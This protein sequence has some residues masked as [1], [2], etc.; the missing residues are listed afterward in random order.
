MN[1]K[2][3]LLYF[4]FLT[5]G[6]LSAAEVVSTPVGFLRVTFPP[7]STSSLSIPLQK[8]PTAVGPI[9]ALGSN[10]VT[11]LQASW[12]SGQFA[13]PS[14]P[15]F[16]KIV[17]GSSAGRYFLITAN[18]ANQLSVDTHGEALGNIAS[19]GN[20]YQISA[21]QTLGSLFGTN[22]VTF[23]SHTNSISADNL[24]I[25]S[26]SAWEVYYHNG[27]NWMRNGRTTPQND[28]V[29]YPDEGIQVV[30]R[31]T[32][33]LTFTIIGEASVIPE[34]TEV[35]GPATTFAANR[36]P[37]PV[38]LSSL[39]LLALP[40]WLSNPSSTIA[41][42]VQ[43]NESGKWITYWHNGNSWCKSGSTVSQDN[44]QISAGT[45]YLILRKSSAGV[46]DIVTQSR[47]Y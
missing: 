38:S 17:S 21:G 24:K 4:S 43:I 36:Y 12:T 5:G 46:N 10:T 22:S 15:H 14:S 19:I 35:S 6:T 3:L 8:N 39:G 7:S 11:D 30:R 27:K 32:T 20:R 47:P 13:S 41:D 44:A 45:G 25:W 34:K 9:S 33:P 16:L 37:V 18:T 1:Q 31:G 2:L 42:R 29:I 28:V 23:F 40:D 26:G